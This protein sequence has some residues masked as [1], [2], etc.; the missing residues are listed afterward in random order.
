MRETIAEYALIGDLETAA[1]VSARGDLAWLCW[2]NFASQ[3]CFA[4]LLGTDTHGVWRLAAKSARTRS[5]RYSPDS[6][7][8]NHTRR[9]F[10]T[11]RHRD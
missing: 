1:L 6:I 10:G 3:A 7:A 4:S 11:D 5:R 2:P 8:R 9:R